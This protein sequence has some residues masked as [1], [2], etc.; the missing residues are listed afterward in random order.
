MISVRVGVA[1]VI[2]IFSISS[3]SAFTATD[4]GVRA[5]LLELKLRFSV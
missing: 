3:A 1:S 4:P 2:T 5:S